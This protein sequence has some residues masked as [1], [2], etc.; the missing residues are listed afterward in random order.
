MLFGIKNLRKGLIAGTLSVMV[1][2]SQAGCAIHYYDE[3]TGYGTYFGLRLYEDEIL[4]S[5]GRGECGEQ[6]D[7]D[8][9]I[10]HKQRGR[11]SFFNGMTEPPNRG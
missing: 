2:M 1:I 11:G 8:I 5:S 10:R 4:C 9:R 6:G 7:G 3:K